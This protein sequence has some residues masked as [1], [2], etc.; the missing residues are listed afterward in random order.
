MG[1]YGPDGKRKIQANQTLRI[2]V[3]MQGIGAKRTRSSEETSVIK[4]KRRGSVI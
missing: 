1:T 4:V 3:S 2:K